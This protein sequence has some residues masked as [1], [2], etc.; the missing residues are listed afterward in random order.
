MTELKHN[1]VPPDIGSVHTHSVGAQ[2][3]FTGTAGRIENSQAAVSLAY[4]SPARETLI[5]RALYLPQS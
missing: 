5:D 2:P 4:A 1:D 3:Q